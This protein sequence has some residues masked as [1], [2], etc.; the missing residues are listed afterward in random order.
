MAPLAGQD[1]HMQQLPKM[2]KSQSIL[3]GAP[4]YMKDDERYLGDC[5]TNSLNL[6][7]ECGV[8]SIAFPAISV[9]RKSFPKRKAAQL[10]VTAVME[11]LKYNPEADMTVYLVPEDIRTF[12]FLIEETKDYF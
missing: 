4:V 1:G 7:K 10:A 6:A 8:K 11:W 9:G 2:E 5:Y 12:H 3:V